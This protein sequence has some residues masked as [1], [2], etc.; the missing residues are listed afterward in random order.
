MNIQSNG[1]Q[2]SALAFDSDALF[3]DNIL[4]ISIHTENWLI[5][6][7][8]AKALNIPNKGKSFNSTDIKASWSPVSRKPFTTQP[9]ITGHDFPELEKYLASFL[10]NYPSSV[11]CRQ[12]NHT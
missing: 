6:H 8:I 4:F 11:W 2:L 9:T 5:I 3:S 7:L 12:S 1:Y 10:K